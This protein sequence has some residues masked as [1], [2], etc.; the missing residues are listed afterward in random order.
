MPAGGGPAG[1]GPGVGFGPTSCLYL[2]S[3][4]SSSARQ[5][6]GARRSRGADEEA[7]ERQ[8]APGEAA[9]QQQAQKRRRR[10]R[11]QQ[12]GD[13]DE[14]MD[15]NI[16][17]TPD[18]DRP[19]GAAGASD[20]GAGALG[21]AGTATEVRRRAAGITVLTGEGLDSKTR[22]PMLPGGWGGS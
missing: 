15:M 19:P 11:A 12:H 3:S 2:V 5:A 17:V 21:F 6:S 20:S 9:A 18:W 14:Y 4:T 10:Q 1:G 22:V 13:G 7:S 8:T 16:E